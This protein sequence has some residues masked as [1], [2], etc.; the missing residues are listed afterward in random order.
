MMEYGKQQVKFQVTQKYIARANTDRFVAGRIEEEKNFQ[1]N[2]IRGMILMPLKRL[3][4]IGFVRSLMT[5][6]SKK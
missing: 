6:F 1:K 3:E 4:N 5:R 2:L